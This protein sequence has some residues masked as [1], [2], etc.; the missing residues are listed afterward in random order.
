MIG[1]LE[2]WWIVT[3]TGVSSPK[4]ASMEFPHHMTTV[5]VKLTELCTGRGTLKGM[6]TVYT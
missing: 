2:R 4:A 6:Q 5:G 3:L 1:E